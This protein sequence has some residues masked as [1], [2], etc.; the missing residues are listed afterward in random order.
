MSAW[1]LA[2]FRL[3][4]THCHQG[5]TVWCER[6]TDGALE[7]AG[8]PMA[9]QQ[10]WQ[11]EDGN[12]LKA[13]R[14]ACGWDVWGLARRCALSASQVRQLEEG[15]ESQFYSPD[16][17]ALA[18]RRALALVVAHAARPSL[19]QTPPGS[20]PPPAPDSGS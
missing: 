18:G 14:E 12:R 8:L 20:S 4:G 11:E 13:L 1:R 19:P 17:K 16:I 9:T 2:T 7:T 15:G 10:V 5:F 6:L 3:R